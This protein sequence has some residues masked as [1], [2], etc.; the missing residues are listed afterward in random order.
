VTRE[1][2]SNLIDVLRDTSL[3][4]AIPALLW[5]FGTT[6]Y[7]STWKARVDQNLELLVA[8]DRK[9]E[10]LDARLVLL[11]R[12][13]SGLEQNVIGARED[14]RELKEIL[15]SQTYSQGAPQK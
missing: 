11:E 3:F 6:I 2:R 4:V 1:Q 15:R 9:R 10:A 14:L 12:S 5:A 8:G 13:V 7:L